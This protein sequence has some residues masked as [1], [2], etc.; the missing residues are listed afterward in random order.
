MKYTI[1]ES[2]F[3]KVVIDYLNELFPEDELH[4]THPLDD[5]YNEDDNALRAYLG[6]SGD[7]YDCFWWYGP[8]WFNGDDETQREWRDRAPIVEIEN[9]YLLPL[10]GYFGDKWHEIFKEWFTE[11]FG[12]S[13]KTIQ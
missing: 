13:V 4:W 1:N 7:G 10:N 3:K 5:F 2:K 12:V 6:D 11:R 9:K 8:E